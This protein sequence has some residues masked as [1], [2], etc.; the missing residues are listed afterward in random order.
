MYRK[1]DNLLCPVYQ[2]KESA[3]VPCLLG[4]GRGPNLTHQLKHFNR[5]LPGR[6]T[7]QIP[8]PSLPAY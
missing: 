6:S 3:A 1:A 8:T 4:V 7:R 5:D 2:V